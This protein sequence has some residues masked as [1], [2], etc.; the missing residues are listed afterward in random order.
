MPKLTFRD[1]S[2]EIQPGRDLLSQLIDA[3]APVMY[4]CMSGSC[5]TCRVKILSGAEHLEPHGPLER[6]HRCK[7]NERLSCQC[8]TLGTGDVVVDQ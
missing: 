1:L 3:G 7:P 4:L 8:R 2:V 6:A 5:R